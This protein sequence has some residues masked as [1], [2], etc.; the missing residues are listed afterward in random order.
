MRTFITAILFAALALA[1]AAATDPGVAALQ[2]YVGTWTCSE[3]EIGQPSSTST[4]TATFTMQ[5]GVL[6]E[7]MVVPP[8]GKM[9]SPYVMT[10]S[11]SFDAKNQRFVR[12][13]LDSLA[14]YWIAYGKMTND[15]ESWTDQQSNAGDL[16]RSDTQRSGRD[17]Y[18]ITGYSSLAATK[19][20][21][22]FSCRR[23]S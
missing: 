13:S 12:V 21:Y 8:Q 2:Y 14:E 20:S 3:G 16:S 11:Y 9:T 18:T 10:T 5:S 15:G 1:A 4:S 17:G 23:S 19:P 6:N 7:T 22:T